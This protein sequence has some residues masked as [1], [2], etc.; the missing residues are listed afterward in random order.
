MKT[1]FIETLGCSRNLVDSEVV[2]YRLKSAGFQQTSLEKAH[3]VL[4]NTCAF[5]EP[6]REKSIQTLFELKNICFDSQLVALGCLVQRSGFELFQSMPE[7]A[8]VVSPACYR[9]LPQFLQQVEEGRVLKINHRRSFL[10]AYPRLVSTYPYVYVKVSEVRQNN[11]AYCAILSIRGPLR[12]RLIEEVVKEVKDWLA[13]GIKEII[14][15]GQDISAFGEDQGENKFLDLVKELASLPGQFWLRLLYLHPARV[16]REL[17][18]LVKNK[19]KVLPYFDLPMQHGSPFILKAMRRQPLP[20]EFLNLIKLIR[21]KLP[22]AFIRSTFMVGFPGEKESD[23]KETVN[24][25]KQAQLDYVGFFEYSEE[26]GTPASLLKNK[27]FSSVKKRRLEELTFLADKVSF[28]RLDK[29]IGQKIK[30]LVE[31]ENDGL[32]EGCFYGQAPQ[33]DGSIFFKGKASPGE[34]KNVL[35]KERVGYDFYGEAI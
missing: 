13:Q 32:N 12:S 6:A 22:Q 1:F 17:I 23:F 4:V 8:G 5:I 10:H 29:F 28:L 9:E 24:L 19:P 26:D 20:N 21:K 25:I 7:L 31:G 15:V 11:C 33:V 3:F 34:W 18:D 16:G 35:I 27:V 30:V 14:L 2:A